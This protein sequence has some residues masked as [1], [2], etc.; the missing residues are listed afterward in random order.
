MTAG[1]GIRLNGEER[2]VAAATVAA[3]LAELGL[4]AQKVAVERNLEIVPRSLYAETRLRPGDA[5]EIVHF[6]GG[7]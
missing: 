7:G 2:R 1:I 4:P 5:I 6:I 3:L